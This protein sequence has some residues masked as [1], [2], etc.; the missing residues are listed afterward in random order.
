MRRHRGRHAAPGAGPRPGPPPLPVLRRPQPLP[1]R[2][3][4]AR[5]GAALLLSG[6][7]GP[8]G[9]RARPAVH[10]RGRGPVR[11]PLPARRR[12]PARRTRAR[13]RRTG[14]G[15]PGLRRVRPSSGHRRGEVLRETGEWLYPHPWLNLLLPHDSAASVV[16]AV[17]ADPAFRDLRDTGLVLLY[18]L[19]SSRLRAPLFSRPSGEVLHLFALL[20]TAPPGSPETVA[21]MVAANRAA[22]ELARS[23]GAVAYPVNAL[24]MS[25]ADW[26]EHHGSR[27]PALSAAK[28]RFDPH[29]VLA[30]GHGLRL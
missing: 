29:L 23:E 25:D 13:S 9:R 30:R 24:P 12:S 20:R 16:R 18:P 28:R 6:G 2:P 1:R 19:L 8:A 26:G 22:Y 4:A 11:R 14:D 15:G 7:P 5:R 27:R 21:A 3:A 17:L 10:D